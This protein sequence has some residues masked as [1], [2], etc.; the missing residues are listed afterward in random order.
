V[1]FELTTNTTPFEG[2]SHADVERAITS[3][4]LPPRLLPVRRGTA[5]PANVTRSD[6]VR[7]RVYVRVIALIITPQAHEILEALHAQCDRCLQLDPSAR[8]RA[9]EL[10]EFIDRFVVR[11]TPRHKW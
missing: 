3:G 2:R 4:Q 9:S 7:V 10:A 8:P 5:S 1:L 6:S 11:K